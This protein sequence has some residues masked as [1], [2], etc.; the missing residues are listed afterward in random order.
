MSETLSTIVRPGVTKRPRAFAQLFSA[1]WHGIDRYFARRAAIKSLHAC[2]D[3]ELRDIGL[4]RSQIDG[5]V[6]GFAELRPGQDT[7]GSRA[8]GRPRLSTTEA[9]PWN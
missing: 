2:N 3:R 7:M 1:C 5:A 4:T 8:E 6:Y 9:D